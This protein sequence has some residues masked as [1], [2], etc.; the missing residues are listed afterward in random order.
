MFFFNI[1]SKLSWGYYFTETINTENDRLYVIKKKKKVLGISAVIATIVPRSERRRL[2]I[3]AASIS[4]VLAWASLVVTTAGRRLSVGAAAVLR[5]GAALWAS[6]EAGALGRRLSIWAASVFGVDASASLVVVTFGG[7]D[8]VRAA[9]MP[10]VG[11]CN[12][13]RGDD[14]L[15]GGETVLSASSAVVAQSSGLPIWATAEVRQLARE[16]RSLTSGVVRPESYRLSVL[17]AS[18]Q[19]SGAAGFTAS[20][21]VLATSQGDAIRTAAEVRSI[22]SA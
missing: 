4:R 21:E 3:G 12:R 13:R 6:I 16:R 15:L 1:Y 2:A 20:F 14:H 7:G 5:L 22:A 18:V 8:A 9:A 10:K 19:R 17:A 11:L